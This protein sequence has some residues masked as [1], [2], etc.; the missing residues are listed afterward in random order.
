MKPDQIIS[1]T[2]KYEEAFRRV[3]TRPKEIDRSITPP[4]MQKACEHAMWMLPKIREILQEGKHAKAERWFC[5]V[6]SVMWQ[7]GFFSI[8][9]MRD[10]NRTPEEEKPVSPNPD[11]C[12]NILED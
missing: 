7:A 4:G 5:F 11:A 6:Q 8:N 12:S 2:E 10:H 1:L 3:G 9:D